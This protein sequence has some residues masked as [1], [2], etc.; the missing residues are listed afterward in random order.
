MLRWSTSRPIICFLTAAP[1]LATFGV[2]SFRR[3]KISRNGKRT[4]RAC[5]RMSGAAWPNPASYALK[6]GQCLAGVSQS[7]MPGNDG[8]IHLSI[9]DWHFGHF[10]GLRRSDGQIRGLGRKTEEREGAVL[11]ALPYFH[12][13]ADTRRAAGV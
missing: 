11:A 13:G 4:W 12:L 8:S 9:R 5:F 3:R 1:T 10:D 2:I 7:F 6:L